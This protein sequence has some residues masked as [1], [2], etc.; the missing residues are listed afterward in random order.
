MDLGWFSQI[1]KCIVVGSATINAKGEPVFGEKL[2]EQ[3]SV[4]PIG[5]VATLQLSR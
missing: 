3:L 4:F 1:H 2:S 5:D